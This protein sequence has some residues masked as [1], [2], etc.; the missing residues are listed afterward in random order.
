[1][2]PN[3]IRMH[4]IKPVAETITLPSCVCSLL[5]QLFAKELDNR[6][7]MLSVEHGEV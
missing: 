2:D 5:L 6:A 1:M 3:S 7:S 4:G